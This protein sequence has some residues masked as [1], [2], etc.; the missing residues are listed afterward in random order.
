LQFLNPAVLVGLVTAL[1]PLAVHLLHRGRTPP[2]P[3]SNLAFL[4]RLHHSRMRRVRLRQWLVLLLRTLIIGLLVCAFA[5]PAYQAGRGWGGSS[6]PTTAVLLLDLSY[7]T[8][9]RLPAGPL[10]AQLQRQA[11]A[12]LE[13]FDR[14]DEVVVVPFARRPRTLGDPGADREHLGERIGELVPSEEA[15]DLETALQAAAQRLAVRPEMDREVFL[16]TDLSHHNWPELGDQRSRLQDARV[17]ITVPDAPQRDNVHVDDVRVRSWM[18]AAGKKLD[19]EV[20]LTNGSARQV[21]ATSLD[22]YVNAERVRHQ[23]VNLRPGEQALVEFTI[24]PRHSGRLGGYV[25]LE[26]DPLPLDNRRYFT[27]DIP[28][29]IGVMVLGGRPA[30]T[31]YPRRALAAAAQAD[32]ALEIRSGLFPELKPGLREEVDVLVLCNVQRLSAEQTAIVRDFVAGGG[33]L[34]LFPAPQADLNF[35]NRDLLPGLLP[36]LVKGVLGDSGDQA[37]FQV[38]GRDK[39][40]HPLFRNLLSAQPED[41]ARFFASFELVPRDELRPM[42]YFSD[43]HIALASGWK[44]RGRVVLFAAPLSLAW[45]DLP[46]KG[47]FVPL[48]HRLVRELSLPADRHDA[49]LVGQTVHRYLDGV[50]FTS[51]IQAETPAGNRLLLEPERIEGQYRWKIPQVGESGLWRLWREGEA[52][53]RFAVNVDVRESALRPVRPERLLQIFG[54]DR[55]YFIHPRDD[56]RVKVLGNRYGRELWREFLGLALVLL[57]LELWVARAPRHQ[58][59]EKTGKTG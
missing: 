31:Y 32:P 1:I 21:L 58:V 16:L 13:L 44:E 4:R 9:Y 17:Y 18:P 47:L 34:I 53:D 59:P 20:V 11:L 2:L 52:V 28:G 29:Q 6:A 14:R 23:D 45:N 39:P 19:L 51:S 41:Q 57:L 43:G 5:R 36:V 35:Y 38:L 37:I 46:L 30:D 27:L 7:S 3:F 48:L 10:F 40:H 56:L 54:A 25:E 26:D 50:P 12:L 55:T 22:L 33:G 49:Y 15:T 8:G 24:I 42:I